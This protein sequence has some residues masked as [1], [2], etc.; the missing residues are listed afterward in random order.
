MRRLNIYHFLWQHEKSIPV[1]KFNVNNWIWISSSLTKLMVRKYFI[2]TFISIFLLSV[3]PLSF[4][5]FRLPLTRAH[6]LGA[7]ASFLIR[8]ESKRIKMKF[9]FIAGIVSGG[10]Q[11][12]LIFRQMTNNMFQPP[13]ASSFA[14]IIRFAKNEL[15]TRS[16]NF[17]ADTIVIS[18]TSK[19]IGHGSPASSDGEK[20]G[21]QAY[22]IYSF[23]LSLICMFYLVNL[24][25]I[26]NNT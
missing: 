14:S 9:E 10:R 4:P 22:A 2:F 19:Y 25:A 11:W 12:M 20:E 5:P 17:H 6:G 16:V 21:Q 15:W 3:T 8:I 24:L 18:F 26:G 13:F 1:D 23:I 7:Y